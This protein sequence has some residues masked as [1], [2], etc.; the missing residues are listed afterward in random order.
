MICKVISAWQFSFTCKIL[1]TCDM[2][3]VSCKSDQHQFSPD[4]NYAYVIKRINKHGHLR[5]NSLIFVNSLSLF[6]N[7]M[8]G[9]QSGELI[10]MW[11]LRTELVQ[12]SVNVS[13]WKHNVCPIPIN[14][15]YFLSLI[16]LKNDKWL[17]YFILF[18]LS[19]LFKGSPSTSFWTWDSSCWNR[20]VIF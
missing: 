14:L 7:E 13:T 19:C 4:N 17:Y 3:H 9:D 6:F 18:F 20:K 1:L 8:Y 16:V 5:E 10:C 2:L 12:D 11:I 15:S